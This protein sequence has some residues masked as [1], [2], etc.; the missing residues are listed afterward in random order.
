MARRTN[1]SRSVSN[2]LRRYAQPL[3]GKS[4]IRKFTKAFAP[5]SPFAVHL[6]KTKI[7]QSGSNP[8]GLV[9]RQVAKNRRSFSLLRSRGR[10][11][12]TC[13]FRQ[14]LHSMCFGCSYS[15]FLGPPARL[16]KRN[17]PENVFPP[18]EFYPFVLRNLQLPPPWLSRGRQQAKGD[19]KPNPFLPR[20][21]SGSR[22]DGPIKSI[23][24]VWPD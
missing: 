3:L 2:H 20:F 14:L 6:R 9:S 13:P 22:S 15:H 11:G 1:R 16:R 23:P 5:C 7:P 4:P 19:P 24:P 17:R 12:K 21:S 8:G 18:I 10:L